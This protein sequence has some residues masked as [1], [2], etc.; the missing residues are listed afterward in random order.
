MRQGDGSREGTR[1]C[2]IKGWHDL[3]MI[4]ACMEISQ[5]NPSIHTIRINNYN[6]IKIFSIKREDR[7][8]QARNLK[9]QN[10]MAVNSSGFLL[11]YVS[12]VDQTVLEKPATPKTSAG[13]HIHRTSPKQCLFFSSQR[14]RKEATF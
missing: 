7:R 1:K 10:D 14:I 6:Y 8:R 2:R 11:I 3:I 5:W 4:Y 9:K 12:L 13:V